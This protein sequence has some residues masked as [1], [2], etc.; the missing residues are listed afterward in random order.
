MDHTEA[1]RALS[2]MVD[3]ELAAERVGPL[4]EHLRTCRDCAGWARALEAV[5]AHFDELPRPTAPSNLREKVI[6]RLRRPGAR[7]L[8]IRPLLNVAAAAAGILLLASTA[9]IF[10]L[11]GRAQPPPANLTAD[12]TLERIMDEIVRDHAPRIPEKEMKR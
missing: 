3:G 11:P 6:E 4:E 2:A 8:A 10:L 12:G 7:L 9:A 1:R 5:R